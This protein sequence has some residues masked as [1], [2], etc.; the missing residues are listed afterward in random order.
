[1]TLKPKS[2]DEPVPRFPSR[3][4]SP[5]P[6]AGCLST[7]DHHRS[8]LLTQPD[9]STQGFPLTWLYRWQW[10]EHATTETLTLMLT[11]HVITVHGKHLARIIEPLSKG[12]GIH[13]REKDARYQ[14]QLRPNETLISD[15]TVL[16]HATEQSALN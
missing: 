4:L 10:R 8:L 12:T 16:P 2:P 14:S 9:G 5:L 15:I 1:M 13:L 3:E 6:E 7:D 11:E